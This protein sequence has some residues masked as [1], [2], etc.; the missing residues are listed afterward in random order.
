VALPRLG[1]Y[2]TRC[3]GAKA[4][5]ERRETRRF[6][7]EVPRL[8]IDDDS[9]RGANLMRQ[10]LPPEVA[11]A[12]LLGDAAPVRLFP[13]EEAAIAR[14]VQA[15]RADFMAGRACAR[16]AL[17][18]LGIQAVPIVTGRSGA[19]QWPDGIVG[20]ITHCPGYG[21][22]AVA[23]QE[24]VVSLGID[25]EPNEVLPDGVLDWISVPKE[26]ASLFEL[27]AT[28]PAVCWDRMLFSAKEAVYKAWYPLTLRWLGFE[29]VTI[30]L[31]P[32]SC[33][34][35]AELA[36]PLQLPDGRCLTGLGG[37]WMV[38]EALIMAT[39]AIPSTTE[40]HGEAHFRSVPQV[41]V[42]LPRASSTACAGDNRAPSAKE[43]S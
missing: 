32:N 23:R 12:E 2:V 21:A 25:A 24:N 27:H 7:R 36:D 13:E 15:R 3:G 11:V 18:E 30:T 10:I 4:H 29:Q 20:S 5:A 33:S 16:A 38:R 6:L 17:Y 40:I 28:E 1:E 9:G 34:F 31:D 19:P 41:A 26:R 37:R 42:V 35:A 22:A 43:S 39:V 8:A 14:A